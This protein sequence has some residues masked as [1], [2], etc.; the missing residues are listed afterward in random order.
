MFKLLFTSLKALELCPLNTH[1]NQTL[2]WREKCILIETLP[3]LNN[4]RK[5]IMMFWGASGSVLTRDLN[6]TDYRTD[7]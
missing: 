3:V 7:W 1:L 6:G 5:I 4:L 2:E